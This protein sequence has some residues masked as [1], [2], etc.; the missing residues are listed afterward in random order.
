MRRANGDGGIS[1]TIRNGKK[2]Y[3]GTVT[4]G[5]DSKGKQVRKTFGSY[6]KS[7]IIDKMNKAKYEVKTSSITSDHITFGNLFKTW[8]YD[9]KK[10]EVS[11]NTF[12]EYEASYRLR[13][14]PY[15]IA[16]KRVN[17]IQL[18]DLQRYFNDLQENFTANTIKKTYIQINSC[19]EFAMIQNIINKNYCKGVTLQKVRKEQSTNV[20][21]KEEQE[22]I[23]NH[24]DKKNVVDN[25]I[26]FTFYTG[27]R[28]GEAL[29]LKWEDI[30]DNIL[31]VRRQYRR[32]VK[33]IDDKRELSYL[34]K[35]LKTEKSK[36][37]IPLPNKILNFLKT[38]E[39]TGE[40]IFNDEGSPLEPKKP[41]RRITKICKDLEIP[42]R[43]FHAIR[44]SY[45]TRLFELDVPIKTVQVL[46]GHS[47]ISTT[48]DIYTHVMQDKKIEVINK[49]ENL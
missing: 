6:K 1:T 38:L 25:L 35:D 10:I 23:F 11:N 30:E 2:Y 39:K 40:L 36:R 21:T 24:L 14:E 41:Q 43:S 48:M 17:T 29:G 5:Y 15:A 45:A 42:H 32:D 47:E 37:E 46:L 44:H 31:K 8:I 4:I 33:I 3:R 7:V 28:L 22:L 20:F 9:Y 27:L 16:N 34:F 18:H 12:Y 13:I 19:F 26:Y 49:L